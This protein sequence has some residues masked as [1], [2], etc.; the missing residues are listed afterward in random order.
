MN[1]SNANSGWHFPMGALAWYHG[2]RVKGLLLFVNYWEYEGFVSAM[3]IHHHPVILPLLHGTLLINQLFLVN[4]PLEV[5]VLLFFYLFHFLNDVKDTSII[6][7]LGS[8][9]WLWCLILPVSTCRSFLVNVVNAAVRAA[10]NLLTD[11]I[12]WGAQAIGYILRLGFHIISLIWN[13]GGVR[14]GLNHFNGLKSLGCCQ[15]CW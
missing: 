12:T 9:H 8:I 1:V 4:F 5:L 13:L 3:T 2:L 7:I 10:V 14:G 6:I 15:V 11:L